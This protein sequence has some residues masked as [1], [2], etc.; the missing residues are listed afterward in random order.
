MNQLI[1]YVLITERVKHAVKIG[2]LLV[3]RASMS[4]L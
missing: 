2:V 4:F 3:D 1:S